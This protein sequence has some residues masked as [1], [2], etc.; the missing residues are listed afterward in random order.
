MSITS[1]SLFMLQIFSLKFWFELIKILN[2]SFWNN[3]QF[4]SSCISDIEKVT[5]VK[6]NGD[7]FHKLFFSVFTFVFRS[8]SLFFIQCFITS[9]AAV[10]L[11]W[12]LFFTRSFI[13][14]ILYINIWIENYYKWSSLLIIE[15]FHWM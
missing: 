1:T 10:I 15:A 12:S 13:N 9:L 14:E 4:N 3:L 5:H 2:N 7:P 11:P 8:I 6:L